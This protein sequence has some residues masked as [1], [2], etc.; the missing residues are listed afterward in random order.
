MCAETSEYKPDDLGMSFKNASPERITEKSS[1]RE[2]SGANP[3]LAIAAA[4]RVWTEQANCRVERIPV[5]LER[6]SLNETLC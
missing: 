5:S 2:V 4:R 6:V 1:F 3:I